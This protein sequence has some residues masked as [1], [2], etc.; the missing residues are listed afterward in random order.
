M[1]RVL[2]GLSSAV[3]IVLLTVTTV[4][5]QGGATAQ[6]SGIVRDQS[7]GV[8]PGVNVT[9][10]QTATGFKRDVITNADGAFSFPTI[11]IGPYRLEAMLQGFRSFVQTGIVLQVN[12]NTTVPVTLTLGEVAETITVQGN[13]TMVETRNLGVGQ[14]LDNRRILD[15]PLNGRNA[16]SLIETLPAAVP[17][18]LLNATSRSMQGGLA[19]SV[20]GGLAF[21]VTYTLDGA[22]HN[23]PYDNLNLPLPFP[24]ALQEARI[25]TSA[26]TA[27]NGM[28][29]GASLT[30]VTKSGSNQFRGNAF[31]FF[32]HHDFNATDPFAAKNPDGSRKD[33]GLVRNQYGTTL[34]GPI[35]TNRLFFFGAFQGTNTDVVPTDSFA[36]VPTQAM[37]TGDFTAYASPACNA[38]VQRNLATP[39]SGNRIDPARFS[40]AALNI[41]GKLPTTTD[42]CGRVQ[43]GLPSSTDDQMY[44][45]KL[46]Y[47]L[48]AKHSLFGRYLANQVVTPPPYSLDAAEQN[49]LVTRIGGRDNLAQSVTIG[50]NFVIS[51]TTLNAV[52]FSYNRTSIHRTST[53][54][55]SAP[56]V[57]VNIYSYMPAY[58]LLTVGAGAPNPTGFQLGG[59]TES[60][61]TFNTNA[62]Q[63]SDDVTLVRGAHQYSF[64]ANV[65]HW[66]S[67]SLANVR[68]PGQLTVDGTITGLPLADFLLGRLGT[69]GFIQAAPNTLDMQQTY[70][71]LYAQDAWQL[72][73]VTL[74]YGLR[75]EPFFPQQLRNG[76]VYQFS[77]DRFNRNVRSTVFPNAPAG[78][79]F[80]G[81]PDFPTSAGMLK[82]WNNLG[83]RVGI[84]W[85]PAGNGKTSVRASYG[86]SYEFVNA[87][88][89]LNTSVAPPWGSEVRMTNPPGGLDDPFLGNPG[90]QTNI[91]PVTFDQNAPF[92]LNGPFL[93]LSNDMVSTNV[94]LWNVTVERQLGA[95]WFASAGY[96]G[97]RTYNIWESAPLNNPILVNVSGQPPSVANQN[98]RRPLTLEDPNN[99]KY[100]Q[101]L[102]LYVTDGQQHYNGMLLQ[103]RGNGSYGS[104]VNA[105]YS[106]GHCYG[107]PDGNGGGTTNVSVGYNKPEDPGYDDGN[108]TADRLQTFSLTASVE[109]GR[110]DNATLRAILSGWRLVGSFR[111]L[112]GPWLNVTTGV[113]RALNN[114]VGTQR[115]NQILDDP[116][117]DQSS[118]PA[119]GGIIYLNAAAFAQPAL[120]TFGDMKR[121]TVRGPGSKNLDMALSKVIRLNSTRSLE[122]RAEA[123]NAFNWFTPAQPGVNLLQTATFGQILQIV[124][125]S[126]RIL[127]FA[128]KFGF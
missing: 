13:T 15:L 115:P 100:Y 75:W 31:E 127:Q 53:D 9:I 106:L 68:S 39:F 117:G 114:Q 26:M 36:F 64:G 72:G 95:R 27:Q 16:A 101:Q 110:L 24:D 78:L 62:W 99:G 21:G 70:M 128:V 124:P 60:Q 125:N 44:V 84:A 65:A 88:F 50:E 28:H 18:P 73:R 80:P 97:S 69:N 14:I 54:F 98:S 96:V 82:D 55:F 94:H 66:T 42:P 52:R 103:V 5:A 33:D 74:N 22:S 116:Y 63:I 17:Q 25:E 40:K 91:F 58:M 126:Q 67:L 8:L 119:N 85:D 105:N 123:F 34:G 79:Y 11:P 12:D 51:P 2:S 118:N 10:T 61:S 104:Y 111:A 112:T 113:D 29:S 90:G 3:L 41:T 81:D 23:N 45:G 57:G 86:K 122:V 48:N 7:G 46:D 1:K 56:D 30:A 121:N 43:Y 32:R 4:W 20:A 6:L 89:H 49:L 120:G 102:D 71:G 47:Q 35:R 109:S 76:A 83:P 108:C 107:S 93:S 19:Y 37:L 77:Q 92:S 38:G 59:G 87:Q